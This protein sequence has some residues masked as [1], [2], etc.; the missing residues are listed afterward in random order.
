MIFHP[1]ELHKTDGCF[2]IFGAVNAAAHPCLNTSIL[3]EFW[4]GFTFGASSL[5]VT[6]HD[7]LCFTLGNA[8]PLPLNGHAY[9][10]RVT[11][12]G[13]CVQ[14]A[15]KRKLTWGVMTLLDQ[16][17]ATEDSED[18]TV[19]EVDCCEIRDTPRIDTRM[20]HFCI[21]PETELWELW[22]FVRL[23]GAL[24]YTHI[25]LEFWGTLR[26]DCL[27]ELSW[28]SAF[29]KEQIRPILREARDLG[30]EVIPLFNHWGHASAGRVAH[31]KH[32]VLD[33]NPALQ[34]Y[35]SED[36]WCW[37]I[38]KPKVRALLRQIRDELIEL[39]G[40]GAYFHIGCDEAYNFDL[41]K[42]NMDF[43]CDF[44]NEISRELMAQ[45]R[46]AIA[47]G[48]MFLYRH[49]RYHSGNRY[50]C[51]A[52]TPEAERYLLEH[53]SRDV[54][55]ADWQ[56]HAPVAPVETSFVFRDKGFDCLLCPWDRGMEEMKASVATV[57]EHAL[58]GIMHTTWH[59]LSLG[60][61]Y[62]VVAAAGCFEDI[63]DKTMRTYRTHTAALLRK[64]MPIGGD[65]AKAGWSK[66]EIASLW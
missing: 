11:P 36:G 61:P 26:Y 12:T 46:R 55:I 14:G 63:S 5:S 21:F 38:R 33:Q 52:P 4:A 10:I 6:E 47:W 54:L 45:G 32:V 25:I 31:G 19:A 30:M 62:V 53:L 40:E 42:E 7:E 48:D 66:I 43:L 57:K 49:P 39:C 22:R 34:T 1:Q 41:T 58:M 23:C 29:T 64:V 16:L 37:D 56:Y 18:R 44:I 28:S 17:H 3:K 27:H 51:N 24:K 60:M 15:D 13:I 2:R 8:E 35:F 20:V 59:T 50:N 65:Y 9:S